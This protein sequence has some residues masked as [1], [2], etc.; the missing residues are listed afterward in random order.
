M[1]TTRVQIVDRGRGPQINGHRITVLDV[2]Y[3]L[4]RGYDFEFIQQ[5]MPTLTRDEFDAVVDYV[6]QHLEE[7]VEQ[8]RRA[9]E[10]IKK[11]V[12]EQRAK[13]GIFASPDESLTAEERKAQL[14]KLLERKMAEKNGASRSD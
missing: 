13:G 8:D 4:N 2:F 1:K 7:L 3:Y 10:R 12:A 5:A 11:G 9:D 14:R 6:D